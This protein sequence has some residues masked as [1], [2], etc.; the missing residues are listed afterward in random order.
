MLSDSFLDVHFVHTRGSWSS[1]FPSDVKLKFLSLVEVALIPLHLAAGPSLD[2]WTHNEKTEKWLSESLLDDWRIKE[3]DNIESAGPWWLGPIQQSDSG[4]LLRVENRMKDTAGLER[5]ATEVLIYAALP[6]EAKSEAS[7]PTSPGSSS[8]NAG[9]DGGISNGI[10]QDI[11]IYALPLCST[12][13]AP[14]D[15]I[16]G[17]ASPLWYN[18]SS[19]VEACFLNPSLPHPACTFTSPRKRQRISNMFED[20]TYKRKRLM[21]HGG[22]RISKAMAA[23]NGES[24]TNEK[25]TGLNLRQVKDATL[26]EQTKDS[27]RD[28]PLRAVMSCSSN[29]SSLQEVESSRPP[30]RRGPLENSKRSSLNRVESIASVGETSRILESSTI[31]QRNKSALTKIV[32]TGMRIYGLQQRKSM[33]PRVEP[34]MKDSPI[35]ERSRLEEEEED[36]KLIYHQTFK[37]ASFAFRTHMSLKIINQE[38]LRDV[39]DSLLVIFCNNPLASHTTVDTFCAGGGEDDT[40]ALKAYNRG[41]ASIA[42]S[43]A[44]DVSSVSLDGHENIFLQTGEGSKYELVSALATTGF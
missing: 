8:P 42:S 13:S 10:I 39:V 31:E 32:M 4:I 30:S 36:Y 7:L 9:Q 26:T 22:D 5:K 14:V 11:R 44:T 6:K 28:E 16:G 41:S 34:E 12:N 20:A 43:N 25:F 27:L 3:D 1:S 23:L 40:A 35:R 18:K 37:A 33:K 29:T 21:K 38:V 15:D 19:D 2:V 24:F 17:L